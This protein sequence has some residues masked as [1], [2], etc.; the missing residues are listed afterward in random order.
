MV[1]WLWG[2]GASI[3]NRYAVTFHGGRGEGYF[4]FLSFGLQPDTKVSLGTAL[5]ADKAVNLGAH[6]PSGPHPPVSRKSGERAACL[7]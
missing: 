2:T 1:R 3:A 6:F 7:S 4:L 5:Q